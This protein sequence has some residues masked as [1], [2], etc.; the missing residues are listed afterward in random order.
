MP[1]KRKRVQYKRETKEEMALRLADGSGRTPEECMR[2]TQVDIDTELKDL[3]LAGRMHDATKKRRKLKRK[4]KAS[5]TAKKAAAKAKKA[6]EKEE[7]KAS[8]TA[9]KASA[10]A[11]KAA[12]KA[13]KAA[14][15]AEK[16]LKF[17]FGKSSG[18][19]PLK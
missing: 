16:V 9:K 18:G 6:A 11:K 19:C 3:G 8:E 2:M 14:E 1:D 4:L 7:F 13:E 15:K 12:E 5:E 17:P 10:K